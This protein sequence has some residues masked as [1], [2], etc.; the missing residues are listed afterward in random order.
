MAAISAH[1]NYIKENPILHTKVSGFLK[2]MV[3]KFPPIREPRALWDLNLDPT[4]LT[5]P[6]YEL[7]VQLPLTHLVIKTAFPIAITSARRVS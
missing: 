1:H 3:N 7:L 4:K 5:G 2:G 6:H